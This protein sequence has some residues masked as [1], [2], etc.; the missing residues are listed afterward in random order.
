MRRIK[1]TSSHLLIKR[2][3]IMDGPSKR[4]QCRVQPS[5]PQ[6]VSAARAH[7]TS[8]AINA[9]TYPAQAAGSH[10]KETHSDAMAMIKNRNQLDF[11]K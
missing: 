11:S 9:T 1:T 4:K 5:R 7:Y 2:G 3:Y 10:R 8:D 6:A